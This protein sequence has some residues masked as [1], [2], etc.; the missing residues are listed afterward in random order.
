MGFVP[1]LTTAQ[2]EMRFVQAGQKVENVYHVKKVGGWTVETMEELAADFVSWW[3]GTQK[4]YAPI[5]LGLVMV[6]VKDLTTQ[7]SAG[8]EYTTGLPLAGENTDE[9]MPNNVTAAV[10]FTTGLRGRSFRGRVY[11]IG[12][13]NQHVIANTIDP[14]HV[15]T[16]NGWFA[17]LITRLGA[18]DAQLVVASRIGGG[19]E[20]TTGISTPVLSASVDATVDSQRRRLPGRGQ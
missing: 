14:G 18:L 1:F 8:I 11:Y 19:V 16:M 17:N 20:R 9:Q 2:V 5:T 3:S 6:A 12:L 7:Y 4:A 13:T 10:K 15:T